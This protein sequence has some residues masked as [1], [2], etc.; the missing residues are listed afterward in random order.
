MG[1]KE[2]TSLIIISSD[3]HFCYL[4]K[5]Y[6]RRSDYR[7]T[8]AAFGDDLL[9]NIQR[10]NPAAILMEIGHAGTNGLKF[11]RELKQIE[12]THLIPLIVFTWQDDCEQLREAGADLTLRMPIL[13][14]DFTS[15][16]NTLNVK[17][18]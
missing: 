5:S 4:M 15:A 16:L 10:L 2:H 1:P 6:A 13:F 12:I 8:V 9:N 18:P 14:D 7:V 11:L 3:A 17:S